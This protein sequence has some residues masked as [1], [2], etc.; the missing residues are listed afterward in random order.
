MGCILLYSL[1]SLI[2]ISANHTNL[3]IEKSKWFVRN[4]INT[5]LLPSVSALI[6]S[7]GLNRTIIFGNG[8]SFKS[9]EV[10]KSEIG[11]TIDT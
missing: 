5:I 2:A 1:W 11:F 9:S 4:P 7:G 8:I 3:D 10:M 6:N